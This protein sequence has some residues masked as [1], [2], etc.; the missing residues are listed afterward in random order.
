MES[1][2][3]KRF[4]APVT[5]REMSSLFWDRSGPDLCIHG[6]AAIA[7]VDRTMVSRAHLHSIYDLGSCLPTALEHVR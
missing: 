7:A 5:L 3:T 6:K 4:K 2:V 1:F